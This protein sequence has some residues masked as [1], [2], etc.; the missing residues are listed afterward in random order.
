MRLAVRPSFGLSE[1]LTLRIFAAYVTAIVRFAFT[2]GHEA[3]VGF[4]DASAELAGLDEA[5]A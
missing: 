4:G 2:P 1:T 3:V 5:I